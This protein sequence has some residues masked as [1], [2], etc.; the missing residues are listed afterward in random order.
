MN[1]TFSLS[2]PP[3]PPYPRLLPP[4]PPH[5]PPFP[6]PLSPFPPPPPPLSVHLFPLPDR[7]LTFVT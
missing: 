1:I 2:H 6:P 5:R 4:F 3:L 7:L